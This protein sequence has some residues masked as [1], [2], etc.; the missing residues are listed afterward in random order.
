MENT[1]ER[2]LCGKD[3]IIDDSTLK[4]HIDRYRLASSVTTD[5]IVIDIACGSG[6]GSKLLLDSGAKFVIGIDSS[7]DAISFAK[8]EYKNDKLLFVNSD[9]KEISLEYLRNF[10]K[11]I[12]DIEVIVSLETIEHL[13]EPEVFLLKLYSLLKNNGELVLSTP[14]TPSMDANPYHLHDFSSIKI[15]K[16]LSKVGFTIQKEIKL[17]Q[18]FNPLKLRKEFKRSGLRKNLIKYYIYHPSKLFLRIFSTI[19]YGFNNI[20]GV[21]FCRK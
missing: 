10:N 17:S 6:Y 4:I 21:Y 11:E 1:L 2:I 16:L 8:R 3:G 19:R 13:D 5:K 18:K 12:D 14:I 15:K 20:Y 7:G 9:Y